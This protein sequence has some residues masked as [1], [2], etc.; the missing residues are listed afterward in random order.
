MKRR[1]R[2]LLL[3]AACLSASTTVA[4]G[5][6]GAGDK[7]P[8]K[9]RIPDAAFQA[10]GKVNQEL[11]P[12]FIPTLDQQGQEVGWVRYSDIQ[13]DTMT[14]A[15]GP[16]P[17]YADDLKRLVGHMYPARGFVPLGTDPESVAKIPVWVSDGKTTW[18][19]DDETRTPVDQPIGGGR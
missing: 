2:A 14:G 19:A 1:N 5:A 11:V 3:A 12:T 16:V 15:N 17:V 7:P 9:G 8:T 6:A 10:D 13:G 18:L 4:W